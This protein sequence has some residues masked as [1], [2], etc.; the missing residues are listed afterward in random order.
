MTAAVLSAPAL[1][2]ECL[3]AIG[4]ARL[5]ALVERGYRPR[6][7]ARRG[8]DGHVCIPFT[9]PRDGAAK[10]PPPPLTLWSDGIVSTSG[11][12]WPD[13]HVASDEPAPDWQRWIMPEDDHRFRGFLESVLPP[14]PV[15]LYLKPALAGAKV[16]ALRFMFGATL[17]TL[18]ALAAKLVVARI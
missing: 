14:G 6:L 18:V 8:E 15:D 4:F 16:F 5:N 12:L 2:T 11:L 3:D 10:R 13:K 1:T 7:G 17:C 9:H